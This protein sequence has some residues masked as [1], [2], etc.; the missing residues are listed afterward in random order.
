LHVS[1][2]IPAWN[3]ENIIIQ[4]IES[5]LVSTYSNFDIIVVAGGSDNTFKYVDH[6][7]KKESRITVIEQKPLGKSS[8][9]N[10][11]LKY[12]TGEIV[13][14]L[15]ADC[16]VDKNWLKYLIAPIINK[17]TNISIGNFQPSTISWVSMWYYLT[18]IYLKMVIDKKN[19]FGGSVAFER[20]VFNDI[21]GLSEK[22]Y[23][24]NY[25]LST[26]LEKKYKITFIE[27]SI[28]QTYIPSTLIQYLQVETRWLRNL[29]HTAFHYN[30]GKGK[31]IFYFFNNIAFTLGLPFFLIL[32]LFSRIPYTFFIIWA[33]WFF[34]MILLNISKPLFVYK[35]TSNRIY[36]KYI[37][38]AL[39]FPIID[40]IVGF[41]ALITYKK[42]TVFFK[43]PRKP[44]E[45]S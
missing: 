32:F 7:A 22:A 9:L 31:V 20:N 43:G 30:K 34:F 12:A 6:F 40:Y 24:D 3:E 14:F 35:L 2:I 39:F 8:A 15:D 5:L 44:K 21:N 33:G 17:E 13:I 36:L 29:L 45:N 4:T 10:D 25:Y 41:Y 1:V 23:S 26:H 38:T 19:F 28:V 18:N 11:G 37:W 27:K 16:L 42:V